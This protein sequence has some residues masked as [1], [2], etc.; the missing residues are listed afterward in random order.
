MN[1]SKC[2]YS[3]KSAPLLLLH[4][5]I[6]SCFCLFTF[7]LSLAVACYLKTAYLLLVLVIDDYQPLADL[8]F[9][10]CL[11]LAGPGQWSL[12]TAYQGGVI[13]HFFKFSKLSTLLSIRHIL[14]FIPKKSAIFCCAAMFSRSKITRALKT[15]FFY[16]FK[17]LRTTDIRYFVIQLIKFFFFAS[18][19]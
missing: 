5:P 7:C 1:N 10:V 19:K 8:S 17:Y 9:T 14:K 13:Q 4:V 6:S 2:K 15:C 12:V 16:I 3:Y 18:Q 11:P